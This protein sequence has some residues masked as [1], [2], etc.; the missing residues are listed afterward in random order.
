MQLRDLASV[1]DMRLVLAFDKFKGTLTASEACEAAERGLQSALPSVECVHCPIADGGDGTLEALAAASAGKMNEVDVENAVAS[2]PAKARFWLGDDGVATLEMA[3]ASGLAILHPEERDPSKATT[4]GT[5]QLMQAAVRAGA[6]ELVIGLGGSA[7]ND[8]G[9]GMARALGYQFLNGRGEELTIPIE[10]VH[11]NKINAPQET[12]QASCLV[13][14]D[15]TAPLLG[16]QGATAVFGPQKGADERMMKQ[17]ESSL[18]QLQK[19]TKRD[20]GRDFGDVPGAGAAGGLGFGLLSFCQATL[21]PGFDYICKRIGLESAVQKADWVITGEGS[22]DLQTLS[23]KGPHG[24]AKLA[25]AHG[26]PIAAI[27]GTIPANDR[28]AIQKEFRELLALTDDFSVD[29]AIARPKEALK[30]QASR[31]GDVL[32]K[33]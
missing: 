27:A 18:T 20:L 28:S 2:L 30:A 5:G 12:L 9:M 22:M 32:A 19:V 15:V 25:Q 24:V 11:L 3:S 31:L 33:V 1:S 6:T 13:L 10:L 4:H 7:T 29:E 21:V 26:K 17:L 14:V 23:G 16:P 8:G